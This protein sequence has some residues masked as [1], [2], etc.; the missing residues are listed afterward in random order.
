MSAFR[1]QPTFALDSTITIN[2]P[3]SIW[4][5]GVAG[6]SFYKNV[7]LKGPKTVGQVIELAASHKIS[8]SAAQAH[9]RWA[10]TR[11]DGWLSINGK[12]FGSQPVVAAQPVQP[13]VKA[14]SK[15]KVKKAA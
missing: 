8:A 5:P 10:Y 1:A 6:E 4:S 11:P 7:L 12:T 13:V 9:L 14:K 2:S 3:K 15:A